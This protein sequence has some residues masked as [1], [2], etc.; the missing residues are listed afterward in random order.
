[1]K[2]AIMFPENMFY[3]IDGIDGKQA[4]RTSSSSPLGELFDHGLDSLVPPLALFNIFSMFGRSRFSG[5]L[6]FKFEVVYF[7]C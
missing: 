6:G 4:R 1:M 3:F 7:C 2:H 5:R